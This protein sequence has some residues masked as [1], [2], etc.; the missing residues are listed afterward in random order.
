VLD[1]GA[2][3][4]GQRWVGKNWACA[5]AMEQVDSEWVL[6][7]DADVRL[8]PNALRR[9]LGQAVAE[10]ADLLSLAPRLNCGCPSE[11]MVQ[12][13]MV[14]LL[15]L[16]FPI[17]AVNDPADTTAFAA[18]PFMLFRRSAYEAI[19]GH[20]ALG[21]GRWRKTWPWRAGSRARAFAAPGVALVAIALQLVLRLW[22]RDRFQIPVTGWWLM[23]LSGLVV[24]AIGPTSVWRTLTSRGWTWKGRPL[25]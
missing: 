11:W 17:S 10:N 25:G 9:A 23:G 20:R 2:R 14:S 22:M 13:I 3:P 19:G 6:F 4:E 21:G 7:L 1:A 16:V 15:V 18:G 5:R 12:P 8:Q 24:G